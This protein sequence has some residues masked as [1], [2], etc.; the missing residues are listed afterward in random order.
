MD[1]HDRVAMRRAWRVRVQPQSWWRQKRFSVR[2]GRSGALRRS[3]RLLKRRLSLAHRSR[4]SPAH[5]KSTPTRFSPGEGCVKQGD[6]LRG[7]GRRSTRTRPR[8]LPV[9]VNEHGEAPSIAAPDPASL[10]ARP[11]LVTP[12]TAFA[13]TIH[14][15]FLRAQV[16]IVGS[17]DPTTLR[18]G[19]GSE[20][21]IIDSASQL[22]PE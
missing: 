14:I 19:A 7:D 16:R 21:W 4:G 5:T 2:N 15:Q 6:S 11:T 10:L 20:K 18:L 17:T 3:G 9:K 13:G 8:L 12:S 22:L 1:G